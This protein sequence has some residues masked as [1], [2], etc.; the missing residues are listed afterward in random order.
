M[1]EMEFLVLVML[2]MST[3]KAVYWFCRW[4]IS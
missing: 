1:S 3:A 4:A 2:V